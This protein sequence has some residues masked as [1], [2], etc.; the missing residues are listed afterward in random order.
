MVLRNVGILPHHYGVT[1]QKT[2][3]LIFTHLLTHS[4]VQDIIWKANSHSGQIIAC[5]LYGTRRFITV[6]TKICLR[7]L[8][9]VSRIQ[10]A[11]SILI[12][13]RSVLMLS[14]HLCL[15][16]PSGLSPSDFFLNCPL[17]PY[18]VEGFLLV[19]LRQL[20]GL[21]GRVISPTQV[22]YLHT[23]QHNTEKRRHTSM[24]RAGFESA[25]STFKRPK[26]VLALD[27]SAIETGWLLFQEQ[28]KEFF[29]DTSTSPDY[30]ED[31]LRFGYFLSELKM[32]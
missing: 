9:W 32:E 19:N 18:G 17:L 26:T 8:S 28:L 5:F 14:S 1:T 3:T 10:F 25:I 16:L 29:P 20:V 27:C 7:T 21:L 15:C 24:P 11:P 22:L 31:S 4:M 6:L 2:S 23:G 30:C 12:S 13:L